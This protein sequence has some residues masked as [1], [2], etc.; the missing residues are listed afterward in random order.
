MCLLAVDC[1]GTLL[2]KNIISQ[3]SSDFFCAFVSTVVNSDISCHYQNYP[4][5][6]FAYRVHTHHL[7]KSFKLC[8]KFSVFTMVMTGIIDVCAFDLWSV[9][10]NVILHKTLTLLVLFHHTVFLRYLVFYVLKI[11]RLCCLL[12]VR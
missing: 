9:P 7:G 4:M 5:H 10:M 1:L 12:Q 11:F 2:E 8:V 3:W 6:V